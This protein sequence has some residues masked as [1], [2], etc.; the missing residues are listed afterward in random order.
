MPL[1]GLLNAVAYAPRH[2]GELL[3]MLEETANKIVEVMKTTMPR[4]AINLYTMLASAKAL[5]VAVKGGPPPL[6]PLQYADFAADIIARLE[7]TGFYEEA[8]PLRR[9]LMLGKLPVYDLARSYLLG[10]LDSIVSVSREL[11]AAEWIVA[12]LAAAVAAGGA[13]AIRA[14][15]ESDGSLPAPGQDAACPVCGRS[16]ENGRCSFC[17]YAQR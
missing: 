1:P 9:A 11:G 13:R 10:D 7:S 12:F 15:L 16:L 5:P 4:H 17:L 14:M 8:R 6:N 3:E 2:R